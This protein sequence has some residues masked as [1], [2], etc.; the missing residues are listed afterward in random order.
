MKVAVS[1]PDQLGRLADQE[2]R[3]RHLPRSR[4]YAE[5]LAQYLKRQEADRVSEKLNEIHATEDSSLP[6][7]V[8]R[9]QSE[10]L[11]REKW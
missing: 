6:E 2:A 10:I 7:D 8:A 9:A 5:A 11:R 3:R 1:I 4:L